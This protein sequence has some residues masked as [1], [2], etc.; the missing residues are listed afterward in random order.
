MHQPAPSTSRLE[1]KHAATRCWSSNGSPPSLPRAIG[2]TPHATATAAPPDEPPAVRCNEASLTETNCQRGVAL[3]TSSSLP[4]TPLVIWCNSSGETVERQKH[5][6][7]AAPSAKWFIS[8]QR[9]AAN[10]SMNS[11][12][13]TPSHRRLRSARS[14]CLIYETYMPQQKHHHHTEPQSSCWSWID[15]RTA[16]EAQD[17]LELLSARQQ[18][19]VRARSRDHLQSNR[20]TRI[21]EAAGQR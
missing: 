6:K 9:A 1:A 14:V 11:G 5:D 13:I 18:R 16:P 10:T 3:Q 8:S 4:N 12:L 17:I 20:K 2:T 19:S 21:G 7:S 15:W